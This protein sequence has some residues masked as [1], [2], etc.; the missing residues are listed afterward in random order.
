MDWAAWY[1]LAVLA[2]GI[3]VMAFDIMGP[4]FAM[5]AMLITVML[6]GEHV[7]SVHQAL[8]GF[9]NEGLLTVGGE[10]LHVWRPRRAV[11]NGRSPRVVGTVEF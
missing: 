7:V 8:E 6:P 3:V 11:G 5:M 4:D 9:S 2:V 1:C 10:L